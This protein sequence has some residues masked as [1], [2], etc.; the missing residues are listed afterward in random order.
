MVLKRFK[1]LI[2]GLSI[3]CYMFPISKSLDML[4]TVLSR[5]QATSITMQNTDTTDVKMEGLHGRVRS[6]YAESVKVTRKGNQMAEGNPIVLETSTYDL[7]GKR[8]NTA[9]YPNPNALE[10]TGREVY[11]YDEKG[12]II[13]MVLLDKDGSILNKETYQYEFDASGNW[14]KM[15]RS[16]AVIEGGKL[17]YEVTEII[18]RKIAYFYDD[19][20]LREDLAKATPTPT[21]SQ[22]NVAANSPKETAKTE[23]T[24]IFVANNLP[25]T[26]AASN[27]PSVPEAAKQINKSEEIPTE[28]RTDVEKNIVASVNTETKAPPANTSVAPPYRFI[29]RS[30]G[31]LNA[32]A[33]SLPK[34]SFPIQARMM[35]ISGVV[36]VEVII[37]S[38]GKVISARATNGP[39]IFHPAAVEAA[40]KAEFMP[41]KVSGE[42]I[43][44]TGLINYNFQ[45]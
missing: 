27:K 39:K 41:A 36:T 29:K 5:E 17:G 25:S 21:P 40:L 18:R 34:P 32:Q 45:P 33:K 14:I 22:P 44:A 12:N 9:Y 37:D 28:E 35:R 20:L 6:V 19:K 1:V 31:L 16:V 23:A 8:V 11:K 7:T 38:N 3:G 13:E 30:Q 2:V 24:P 10:P 26:T 42:G 43:K 15:I 4:E